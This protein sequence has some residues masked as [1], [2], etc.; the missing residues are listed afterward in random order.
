MLIDWMTVIAQIV[1]FF[2]LVWLLN[3][4]LFKPVLRVVQE[5]NQKIKKELEDA[6]KEKETAQQTKEALEK[7]KELFQQQKGLILIQA[8]KEAQEEKLKLMAEVQQEYHEQKKLLEKRL[9]QEQEELIESI[10]TGVAE[11]AFAIAKKTLQAV[12]SASLEKEI[13]WLFLRKMKELSQEEIQALQAEI[14]QFPQSV[15][16]RSAFPLPPEVKEEVGLLLRTIFG[17]AIPLSYEVNQEVLCGVQL[18]T[19]GHRVGWNIAEYISGMKESV[20][21]R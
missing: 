14:R 16:I 6:H 9:R 19:V 13:G 20:C 1:N 17:E 12:A 21:V 18:V 2:T 4:F 5:R 15:S 8:E 11:E 10:Q 3:R 7:E